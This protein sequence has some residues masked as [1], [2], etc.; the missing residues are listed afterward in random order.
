MSLKKSIAIFGG[1][2]FLGKKI[3]ETGIN[4]GYNVASFSRSGK[5][6]A[7][8]ASLPWSQQVKWEK[9]DIFNPTTYKDKLSNY[10]TVV[11]SI[12]LLFENQS[13]KKSINTNFN[14]LNDLQTF[15][16][17][18]KGSNPMEK[19][20][21]NTYEAIQR[22]SAMILADAFLEVQPENP[23]FVYISADRQMPFIPSG[24]LN[25]KREA[26]FELSCKE[27][28]RPIL[29]RPNFMYDEDHKSLNTRD[30]ITAL[31]KAGYATK[32]CIL[33]DR[34]GFINDLVRAPVSTERVSGKIYEKI[35]EEG[36]KGIVKLE[37][38][39]KF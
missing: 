24:Y 6:P 9:A 14:F 4:L 23:T 17:M 37:D 7:E 38:I 27:G 30:V 29:M 33:H 25:T 26:E 15:S 32:N 20:E 2:G 1:N 31:M 19:S 3:C 34:I 36:F 5:V 39:L 35:E 11:H 21:G 28:L 12:G 8:V 13:Y 10:G 22:D 16:N 18:L